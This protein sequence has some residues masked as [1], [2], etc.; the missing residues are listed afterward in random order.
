MKKKRVPITVQLDPDFVKQMDQL[1]EGM[2]ISRGQLMR[3]CIELGMQ[4]AIMIDSNSIIQAIYKM[5]K[6]K[7][8]K[9]S[10]YDE[11]QSR[12]TS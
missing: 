1:A 8:F 9:Q 4:D 11:I 10:L 2:G 6:I 7:E 3:Q 5:K 12:R